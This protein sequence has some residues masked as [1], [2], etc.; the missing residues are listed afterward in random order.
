MATWKSE[1]NARHEEERSKLDRDHA[2][3][4]AFHVKIAKKA[5]KAFDARKD[6]QA[7][8]SKA[9]ENPQSVSSQTSPTPAEV[10][11]SSNSVMSFG[12]IVMGGV[13]LLLALLCKNGVNV[14]VQVPGLG[15]VNLVK[16]LEGICSSKG[17]TDN[18]YIY[19]KQENK[20]ASA[21][22]QPAAKTGSYGGLTI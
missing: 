14:T 20:M 4:N 8:A 5:K 22:L 3:Q 6:S 21:P 10:G 12:L 7:I 19:G 9:M 18:S 2:E 1:M 13:I 16:W 11:R 15:R 17:A